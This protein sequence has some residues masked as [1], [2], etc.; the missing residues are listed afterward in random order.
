MKR[1]QTFHETLIPLLVEGIGAEKYLE[2]GTYRN[3]TISKVRCARRY[4]VDRNAA[5]MG[6]LL[7]TASDDQIHFFFMTT[8]HFIENEAKKYAPFDVCFIDADHSYEASKADFEG[9]WPYI[10]R[11]GLVLLHDS[12][13]ET[14]E[15]TDPGF[16]GD[17]WKFARELAKTHEAVTLPYHPGLTIVRK[18]IKWGPT[19]VISGQL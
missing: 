8:K 11:E 17:G 9:I 4:G 18:R 6:V 16:C 19:E 14:L 10:S 13:P 2:F 3:D 15:D 1:W 12:N 5:H 7:K